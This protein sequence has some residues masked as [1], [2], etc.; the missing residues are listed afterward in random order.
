M[1]IME[2]LVKLAVASFVGQQVKANLLQK[3]YDFPPKSTTEEMLK[4]LPSSKIDWSAYAVENKSNVNSS[5]IEKYW[6]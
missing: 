3:L 5:A 1:R 4:T 2:C 6:N